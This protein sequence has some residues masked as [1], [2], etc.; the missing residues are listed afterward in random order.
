MSALTEAIRTAEACRESARIL[1][2]ARKG[3]V[4][5]GQLPPRWPKRKMKTRNTRLAPTGGTP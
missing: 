2:D 4:L 3:L 1:D 5:G